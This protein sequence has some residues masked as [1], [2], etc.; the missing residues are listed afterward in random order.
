MFRHLCFILPFP[1]YAT[2]YSGKK[3]TTFDLV[4]KDYKTVFTTFTTI[5]R[6]CGK[7]TL[8]TLEA[9]QINS[10][11]LL[12]CHIFYCTTSIATFT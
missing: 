3:R 9:L 12:S 10:V 4:L 7:K 8:R 6:A 2:L 11:L 1:V 5:L